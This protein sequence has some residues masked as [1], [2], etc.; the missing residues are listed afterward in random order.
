MGTKPVHVNGHT[1]SRVSEKLIRILD[2]SITS[3]DGLFSRVVSSYDSTDFIH[4]FRRM[5]ESL[6]NL[7]GRLCP[8]HFM[9]PCRLRIRSVRT[10]SR[11]LQIFG[12]SLPAHIMK[13]G[14]R[15]NDLLVA[16]YFF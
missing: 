2:D 10:E 7:S 8:F 11:E 15:D 9:E 5:M 6:Q 12:N 14:S 4:L 1:F 3:R 16:F 13:K